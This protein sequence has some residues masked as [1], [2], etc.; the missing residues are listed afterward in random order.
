MAPSREW[1]NGVRKLTLN[2]L[3]DAAISPR[4]SNL[5]GLPAYYKNK[6]DGRNRSGEANEAANSRLL[7]LE[8]KWDMSSY[9]GL[10]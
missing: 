10:D 7:T 1:L 5:A 4:T 6:R 8:M 9:R 2:D 3:T